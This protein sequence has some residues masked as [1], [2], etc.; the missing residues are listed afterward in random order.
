MRQ[1]GDTIIAE[2]ENIWEYPEKV[3]DWWRKTEVNWHLNNWQVI[4]AKGA[5]VYVKSVR[6]VWDKLLS[7]LR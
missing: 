1:E 6:K 2:V 5:K 7:K 4:Q 3:E